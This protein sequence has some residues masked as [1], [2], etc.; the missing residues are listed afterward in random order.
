MEREHL[1]KM[2]ELQSIAEAK[3]EK[4]WYRAPFIYTVLSAMALV[5]F[6]SGAWTTRISN[7]FDRLDTRVKAI[8]ELSVEYKN[9]RVVET[10]HQNRRDIDRNQKQI[11]ALNLKVL[12]LPDPGEP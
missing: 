10:V 12:G 1:A 5:M 4:W 8:E 6:A 9:E 7:N 11:R 3:S 2:A